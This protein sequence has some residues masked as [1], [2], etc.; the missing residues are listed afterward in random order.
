[1]SNGPMAANPDIRK[2]P[3]CRLEPFHPGYADEVISWVRDE[4]EALW[5]APRSRP[6]LTASEVLNWQNAGHHSYLLVEK[7][8]MGGPV[9]YGELNEL[10]GA[11]RR[12]WLGH[13]I[14]ADGRRGEGWGVELTRRLLW[15]GFSRRG[16]R[17]ITLV[18]FPD[19]QRAISCYK[20]AGMEPDGYEVHEFPAYGRRIR[21]LRMIARSL[22]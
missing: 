6:P 22:A 7:R 4:R 15:E 20:A 8:D 3:A 11:A 19:N 18:V 13:L 14:V 12:Y 10:T 16:A 1:M 2:P 5:L 9:A 17:D 21:L